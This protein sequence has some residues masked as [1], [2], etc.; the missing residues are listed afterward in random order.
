MPNATF[1]FPQSWVKA[2]VTCRWQVSNNK[3]Y[4]YIAVYQEKKYKN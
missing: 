4:E 1:N 3:D 2:D